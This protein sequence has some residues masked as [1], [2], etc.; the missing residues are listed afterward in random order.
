M[1]STPSKSKHKS[2]PIYRLPTGQTTKSV[3]VRLQAWKDIYS[4]LEEELYLRCIGFDPD[5]LFEDCHNHMI[6]TVPLWLA[7]KIID[8]RNKYKEQIN[9]AQEYLG[10]LGYQIPY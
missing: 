1:L 4:I 2:T 5:F 8:M 6:Q 9:E 7:N 3:Q 10:V